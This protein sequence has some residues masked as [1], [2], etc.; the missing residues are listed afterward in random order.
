MVHISFLSNEMNF[1]NLDLI[2]F[3]FRDGLLNECVQKEES[4][5]K[6][7]NDQQQWQVP[8]SLIM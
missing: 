1:I 4:V 3:P 5:W 7:E 8:V 6:W 2:F